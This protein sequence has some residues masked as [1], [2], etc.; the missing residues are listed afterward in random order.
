MMSWI[1]EFGMFY[2]IVK[3]LMNIKSKYEF[4]YFHIY[5]WNYK[6]VS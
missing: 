3:R 2:I 6:I 4:Y 5:Y 1:S